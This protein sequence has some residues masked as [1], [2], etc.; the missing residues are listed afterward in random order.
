M[1]CVDNM[2]K[3]GITMYNMFTNGA[4]NNSKE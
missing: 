1:L 2:V 3:Y 4:G